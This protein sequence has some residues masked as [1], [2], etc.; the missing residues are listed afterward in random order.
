VQAAA[1]IGVSHPYRRRPVTTG[2]KD[3]LT[4]PPEHRTLA[5]TLLAAQ[6]VQKAPDV[7]NSL[8]GAFC[9]AGGGPQSGP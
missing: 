1:G 3:V 6:A 4:L 2:R 8:S 9:G 7:G 5:A